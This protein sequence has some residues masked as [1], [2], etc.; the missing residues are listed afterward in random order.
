MLG[1]LIKLSWLKVGNEVSWVFL[2]KLAVKYG[3][4]LSRNLGVILIVC[5]LKNAAKEKLS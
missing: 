3:W 4:V 2:C 1:K 5:V